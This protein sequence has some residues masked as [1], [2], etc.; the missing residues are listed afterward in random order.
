MVAIKVAD[1]LELRSFR[2][3]DAES[4]FAVVHGSRQHL[5][6]WLN[7]VSKTTKPEHSL[8]FIEQS[9]LKLEEQEELA[10]A[11]CLGDQ[12]IGSVGMLDWKHDIRIA[13]I[14]YWLAKGYEGNGIVHNSLVCFINFLFSNIG[15]NKL[16]IRFVAANKRSANV[17]TKLGFKIEGVIRQTYL[18][19][20]H[21]EDVVVM[22][23]LKDEWVGMRNGN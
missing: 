18:R 21:L 22:G 11:I 2:K 10:L 20:G 15:L 16:E 7:W 12:I 9:I 3:E 14:G 8:E 17:A 1:G 23:M 4:L 6:P 5:N 19:N 13:Q